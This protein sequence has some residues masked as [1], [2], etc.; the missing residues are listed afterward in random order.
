[1]LL[2]K[3]DAVAETVFE[4]FWSHELFVAAE[5]TLLEELGEQRVAELRARGAAMVITDAV[6]FLRVEVDRILTDQGEVVE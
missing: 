6:A 3:A 5:A 4:P 1:M 2:G